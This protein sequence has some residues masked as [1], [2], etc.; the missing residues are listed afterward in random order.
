MEG[1]TRA[2]TES[3]GTIFNVAKTIRS[4]V[5][6]ISYGMRQIKMRFSRKAFLGVQTSKVFLLFGSNI[7]QFLRDD[8]Q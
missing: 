6:R 1:D 7:Q 3:I 2:H 8:F 4:G 5:A